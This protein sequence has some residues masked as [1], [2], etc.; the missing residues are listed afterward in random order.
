MKRK[1]NLRKIVSKRSYSTEE[2]AELL[3]VHIQTIRIWRKEGLKP[4]EE[5]SSPFLFLGS[6]IR[7]F[8]AEQIKS[9]KVKLGADELYCLRCRKA[10]KPEN[11]GIVDRNIV[12]GKGKKST[13]ITGTCPTCKLRLRRFSTLSEIKNE[14]V[15]TK[16]EPKAPTQLKGQM[17]LFETNGEDG[18]Y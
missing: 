10:V 12:I 11:L 15:E 14:S 7:Q 2:I 4:I 5:H 13:F 1:Y 16:S 17:G 6:D 8:L 3:G 9:Q 18:H